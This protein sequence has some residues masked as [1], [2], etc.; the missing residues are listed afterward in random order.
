[1]SNH[2]KKRIKIF[3]ILVLAIIVIPVYVFATAKN[4]AKEITYDQIVSYVKS[5]EVQKIESQQNS[6]EIF[7][8][9]RDG[10]KNKVIVPSMEEFSTFVSK[11]IENGAE[12][13]FTVKQES[14]TS[15]FFLSLIKTFGIY[16]II[17][18]VFPK[19]ISNIT[20]EKY[21]V[22]PVESN[23]SFSDVAGIEEEKAQL[24]EIVKFLK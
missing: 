3:L 14:D 7:V 8:T 18:Y 13:K 15:D 22:K 9:L 5:G 17:L 4:N 21:E 24:E 10:T 11:E 19:V 1:M 23:V 2:N 6:L 12:I 20:G 16:A